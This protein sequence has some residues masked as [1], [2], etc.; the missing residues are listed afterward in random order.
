MLR[1]TLNGR[2]A[3]AALPEPPTVT[4]ASA[5]TTTSWQRRI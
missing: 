4:M 2:D 5:A 1:S 3:A